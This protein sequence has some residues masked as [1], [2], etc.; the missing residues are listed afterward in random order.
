MPTLWIG[1]LRKTGLRFDADMSEKT[2]DSE[3]LKELYELR[4][5]YQSRLD[6]K[7]DWDK[8]TPDKSLAVHYQDMLD[9]I[10]KKIAELE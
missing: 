2:N 5:M 6:S 4:Q 7:L 8:G 1:T 3:K 9:S 10:N